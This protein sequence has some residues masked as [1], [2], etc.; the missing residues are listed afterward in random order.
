MISLLNSRNVN[1]SLNVHYLPISLLLLLL[2]LLLSFDI[3]LQ[4]FHRTFHKYII[5]KVRFKEFPLTSTSDK[6][7]F[8]SNWKFYDNTNNIY[9]CQ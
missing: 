8:V 9:K 3:S 7:Y 1:I 6:F 5:T 4:Q 2:L